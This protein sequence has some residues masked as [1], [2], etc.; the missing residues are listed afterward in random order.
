M[1]T[2]H[3]KVSDKT[4]KTQT[5]LIVYRGNTQKKKKTVQGKQCAQ[6]V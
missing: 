2:K 6:V 5:K 3:V 4:P 1:K